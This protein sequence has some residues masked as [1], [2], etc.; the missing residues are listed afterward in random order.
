MAESP[1]L[2][3]QTISHYHIIEKLGGG[4]MGVVY[5][6]EDTRLH[7][8][9]ALKFLPEDV[10]RDSQALSRF[11]REAQAASALNHPNI[12]TIYDIGGQDGQAFIA[13]EFLDGITLKHRI[14]GR[15][16]ELDALLAMSTEI[17]DAL[18]AAHAQGIIH[19]DIKPANVF[20]T[21]RGHA[22]I[23]DF[24][25]A[26]VTGVQST[27]PLPPG[28]S[29]ATIDA[30]HEHLTSPGTALGT[31]AYMSPEQ[32]LGK[33]LD[34]RTDLFSFGTVLYEMA[35]GSLP[36]RGETSAAL[37]DSILRK[38]PLAPVR[39]NPD[40]PV[41]LEEII[42]K[43]L[44][45]DRNLRYQ[46][47]ADIRADLQ[48]LK[49]D[50]DSGQTTQPNAAEEVSPSAGS[51]PASASL[52][53]V[54][55]PRSA[56]AHSTGQP[57]GQVTPEG[58]RS[59]RAWRPAL[60]L[61]IVLAA[62]AGVLYW[63]A[64]KIPTLTEK[65]TVLLSDFVNNTGD[66]VFDDALK[67][68]LA[69]SLQQ[70]PFLSLVSNEQVQ[71]TLRYMGRPPNTP[72]TQDV[73]HEVC[74]RTQSKAM[75]TGTISELGSQYVVTLE[76]VNCST[77]ASLLRVGADA[78][79]KDKVLQALGK[80][81]A[82]LRGKLGESLA[83]IQKF[84]APLEQATTNSLE[85]LK[86]FSLGR[87]A[88]QEKGSAAGIPFFK[89]AIELDPNFADAYWSAAAMYS[90]IGET[91][92][93]SEYAHRAYG[94]R[95]RVTERE[96]LAISSL[97]SSYVTGD[98]AKADQIAEV[99][100]QTYPRDFLFYNDTGVDKMFRGDYQGGLLDFQHALQLNPGSSI[101]YGNIADSYFALNRLDEA[102]T[103]L[104]QGL[105]HGI[106]PEALADHYYSLAFLRNDTG[107]MQKQLAL[108]MD[109]PGEEDIL[110]SMQSDTQAYHGRLKQAREYARRAAES[111]QGNAT[112]ETAAGWLV[113][114][115][116]NEVE[117]GNTSFAR[118]AVNSALRLAPRGRYIR[119][120]AA[121]VLARAGDIPQAQRIADELAKDYPEDTI[122]RFY[123]LSVARA[124]MEIN[125]HSPA[126]ALELLQAVQPYELGTPS[127]TVAPLCPIYL[128][129]YAYLSGGQ[130]KEAASE[131]Q[132]IFD[133]RGIV[134]NS[135]IGAVAYLGLARGRAASGD[136]AGAGT[137]YQDF[138]ALWKDADPDIPILKQAKAEYA[139]LR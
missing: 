130:N 72:L 104:D 111:S 38:T 76:A 23:L 124:A 53:G 93:A 60:A 134:L 123:W 12:C 17:A 63:R 59:A 126:K 41:R 31:V 133:H 28:A 10:A 119:G 112:R 32:A 35:T 131:F 69:V 103:I 65:D 51:V 3:G 121:F 80:A 26:K 114:E 101:T 138:F 95:D 11:R 87:K 84:D 24:G 102:K 14:G 48:R 36:F 54:G 136:N 58:K 16:L 132:K 61:A 100:H 49:R 66:P 25:L 139:K 19:R 50:T 105:A 1:S 83:S 70:S 118:Q 73:A 99:F 89:R 78:P 106:A 127:P 109:K 46:H 92:L 8:F 79:A 81:A 55:G 22:K 5:K 62:A 43:A 40:L 67:Q 27:S 98:L 91:A 85:A 30:T 128:R 108:A 2:I 116:F 45:K 6:A 97:E 18:D 125:R 75:L 82:E 90:N 34:P 13:M 42:N 15:P 20:V 47:A 44:E 122:L 56:P 117:F 29:Q 86:A 64:A 77:G 110:L 135:P 120:V 74:Q 129:G 21:K 113:D 71:Q 115:A 7:R 33:E 94:L 37:F 96:R 107:A 68:A 39:L 4:G 137:A 9:V 57:S 52:P 88:V